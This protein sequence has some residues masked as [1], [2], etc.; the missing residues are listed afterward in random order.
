MAITH[1][2]LIRHLRTV[3]HTYGYDG[4]SLSLISQ[5]TGLGKGSLYHHF[6]NGKVEMAS[7]VLQAEGVWFQSGLDLLRQAG[8]PAH[9]LAR[10][11]EFVRISEANKEQASTLDVYTMGNARTLFGQD[12]G[13]AV[14]EWIAAL[15][16]VI[17][18]SGI[19]QAQARQRAISAIAR[20]EGVR[21][22]C[23]CLN[24]WQ[25][26]D[27]LLLQLPHDLLQP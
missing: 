6:P 21:L 22:M 13:I 16:Q 26:F 24:D 2:E 5:A 4:A 23:R 8:E 12:M 19:A 11:M 3:F 15:Q 17:C 25:I 1:D 7:A 18:D 27:D 20:L 14:Q 9:R 10:F